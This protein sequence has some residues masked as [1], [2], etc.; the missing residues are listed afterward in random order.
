MEIDILLATCNGASFLEEQLRSVYAGKSGPDF[1]MLVRDDGST[2]DTCQILDKWAASAPDFVIVTDGQ[3][4]LGTALNYSRLMDFVEAQ[5]VAF[6][7][8]DDVWLPEKLSLLHQKMMGVES[9]LGKD[10]PLLVHSDLM[11]VD[12]SLRMIAPSFWRFQKIDPQYTGFSATLVQNSVTGCAMMANRALVELARPVPRQAIMHD[13]WLALVASAF[14]K[15][16]PIRKPLLMYRQHGTNTVGAKN[17]SSGSK[18]RRATRATGKKTVGE[19]LKTTTAQCE[20]FLQ[21]YGDKLTSQQRVIA[22]AFSGITSK[23]FIER[24]R[25]LLNCRL[26]PSNIVRKLLWLAWA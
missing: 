8:Q 4:S 3:G 23:S 17:W 16:V 25:I 9:I 7:D 2:D 15:V 1:R 21:R 22:E 6:S 10:T 13:W 14:G 24:R 20:I 26:L 12:R 19:A 18:L 5:Y 11:V